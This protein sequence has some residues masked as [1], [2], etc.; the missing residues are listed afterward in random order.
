MPRFARRH[1]SLALWTG[2]T[3]FGGIDAQVCMPGGSTPNTCRLSHARRREFGSV[4]LG[5]ENLAEVMIGSGW[6]KLRPKKGD[7]P[8]DET[9]QALSGEKRPAVHDG[10]LALASSVTDGALALQMP[11]KR[12]ARACGRR[13]LVVLLPPPLPA[14]RSRSR[15]TWAHTP[16]ARPVPRLTTPIPHCCHASRR[17]ERAG[18]DRWRG[19][20][21]QRE[22]PGRRP[23]AGRCVVLCCL[24]RHA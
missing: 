9:L 11:R 22:G 7:Y 4:F 12:R 2:Q 16:R 1:T 18:C 14:P 3:H 8:A 24:T 6:A 19:R 13:S 10:R 21:H 23:P 17:R 15:R 5:S 20:R